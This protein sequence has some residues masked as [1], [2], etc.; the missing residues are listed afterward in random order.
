MSVEALPYGFSSH[1]AL[2]L[3]FLNAKTA[4]TRAAST[5][6]VKKDVLELV[7]Q[8][9]TGSSTHN[10][11]LQGLKTVSDDDT[12]KDL[13]NTILLINASFTNIDIALGL[14]DEKNYR[15]KKAGGSPDGDLIGKLR[16]VW[17]AIKNVRCF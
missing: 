4:N 1:P 16:P 10:R 8:N 17:H 11:L 6:P 2:D 13:T 15:K 9:P 5:N 7:N 12:L 14:L 3:P